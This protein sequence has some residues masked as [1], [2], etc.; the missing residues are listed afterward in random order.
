MPKTTRILWAERFT[1]KAGDLFALQDQIT[2]R[3]AVALD[4]ELIDVEASRQIEA[5]DTRDYILRG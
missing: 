4:L 2:R 3:I 1:G 5:P